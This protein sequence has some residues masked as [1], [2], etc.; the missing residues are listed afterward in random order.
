MAVDIHRHTQDDLSQVKCN[1]FIFASQVNHKLQPVS[2]KWKDRYDITLALCVRHV[3][4]SDFPDAYVKFDVIHFS[5]D[6]NN[7]MC[8]HVQRTYTYG[9]HFCYSTMMFRA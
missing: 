8:R 7:L 1:Q 4:A 9:S 2:P 3:I 5:G 6:Q